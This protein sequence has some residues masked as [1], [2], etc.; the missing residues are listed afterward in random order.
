M[1]ISAHRYSKSQV[2]SNRINKNE[3][4]SRHKVMKLDNQ[5]PR[6]KFEIKAEFFLWQIP[7]SN[8][9]L[10]TNSVFIIETMEQ[11]LSRYCQTR[12]LYPVKIFPKWRWNEI[13]K[14]LKLGVCS[15][16]KF[17]KGNPKRFR[18]KNVRSN[19]RKT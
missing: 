4:I 8:G 17:T 19:L 5:R 6:E 7:Q 14:K 9:S 10:M 1:K 18:Q 13:S 15:Q 2:I 12:I 16:Q 3:P 11:F